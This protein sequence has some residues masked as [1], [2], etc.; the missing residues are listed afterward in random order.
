MDN[1]RISRYTIFRQFIV[2]LHRIESACST[3]TRLDPKLN[4]AGLVSV[5]IHPSLLNTPKIRIGWHA[6]YN[7]SISSQM[8]LAIVFFSFLAIRTTLA[9]N[10]DFSQ[11][12]VYSLV[13][14]D[15]S[16]LIRY[17]CQPAPADP[18]QGEVHLASLLRINQDD[19]NQLVYGLEYM[20]PRHYRIQGI[21]RHW[22]IFLTTEERPLRPA[23]AGDR[24]G[25]YSGLTVVVR[26]WRL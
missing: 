12:C 25:L 26:G 10:H 23:R 15:N 17:L 19:D 7:I 5:L 22:C 16:P 8:N 1:D 14:D 24:S 3:R 11:S 4:T 21:L 20:Q 13:V 18:V 9:N 6:F 2:Y